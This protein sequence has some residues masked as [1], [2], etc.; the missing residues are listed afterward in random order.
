MSAP[1]VTRVLVRSACSFDTTFVLVIN[2][3]VSLGNVWSMAGVLELHH[4]IRIPRG[5][6]GHFE[7]MNSPVRR[8]PTLR[9]S[10]LTTTRT[11]WG[12][13]SRERGTRFKATFTQGG[14][15]TPAETFGETTG[16][17]SSSSS[18]TTVT[19]I[20]SRH[21]S[22]DETRHLPPCDCWQPVRPAKV[23][24]RASWAL[25]QPEV[26]TEFRPTTV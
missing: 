19:W 9:I 5:L 26:Q 23:R 21:G 1:G 24:T 14:N 10:R 17:G 7:T 22:P 3:I 15:S 11:N 25:Q 2:T 12:P 6:V 13:S 8:P 4:G 16:R 20:P 18:N